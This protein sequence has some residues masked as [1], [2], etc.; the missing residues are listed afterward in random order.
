MNNTV[1]IRLGLAGVVLAVLGLRSASVLSDPVYTAGTPGNIAQV[2]LYIK[3]GVPPLNMLVMGKDTK[4]YFEAYNDASDLDGD[5]A[6]DIG[7]KPGRIDYYGYFN[8]NVCYTQAPGGTLF[9]PTAAATN[10]QCTG[11]WSGDFLNYLTTSRMDALRRVLYGGWRQVDTATQ[12]ILQGAFFPQ[13]GHSWGKEYRSKDANYDPGYDLS[14]YAPYANPAAG[15]YTLFAV[16]TLTGSAN[17]FAAGYQAPLLRVLTN[18]DKRVWNWLSI[19]GP[20][21]GNKCFT[22]NN[23]RVD[24]VGGGGTQPFPGHPGTR[25]AF[26]ALES[27]FATVANRFGSG[28]VADAI[29]CASNDCNPY[30]PDDNYMAIIEGNLVMRNGSNGDGTYQFRIDGDDVVDFTLYGPNGLQIASAGCYTTA[31]RGFGACNGNETSNTVILTRR[32]TYSFKVRQEEAGGGDGY[33]LSWRKTLGARTF[34]WTPID[35]RGNDDDDR[36]GNLNGTTLTTYNLTPS[37]GGAQRDDYLVRVLSC[38]SGNAALRDTTCKGYTSGGTTVYKPTGIL[39]DYGETQKMYFGLITGSQFN[40]LEGGVLRRNISNFADEIDASDGTFRTD[41]NGIA[42]NIDRFRMI[43][44]GYA[45]GTTNNLNSDSNWSWNNNNGNCPTP[46]D[47]QPLNNGECRMWGNPL[48][49]MAYETMRY[50]AGANQPTPRFANAGNGNGNNGRAE[51]ATMGLTTETWKDPYSPRGGNYPSCAKPFQTLISDINPSYDGDLPGSAFAGAN[52]ATGQTP[53]SLDAFNAAAEGQ[54]IWDGEFTGARR[55]FIGEVGGATDGAPTAKTASSFG[56]IRGL[57]PEEPSK[58]GTYYT[59]SVARYGRN[60]DLN[61]ALGQQNM[62]TYSVALASPLPRIDFPV[63][64]GNVTL[65]PFAKTASGTFGAGARKPTNTIVDF[66]VEQI[67]NLPGQPSDGSINGGRPSAIFRINYEDSEQGNDFDMDAIVRYLVQANANGTV[68]VTLN[69]EYA[70]GSADQNMGFVLSGTTQDGVYLEVRDLDAEVGSFRR[71]DLNTPNP[72]LPGQCVGVATG[73]CN[74]QLPTTSTRTFT[75]SS[76]GALATQLRDPLWYAAK[77]GAPNPNQVDANGDGV[78]DNYLLVTNPLNLRTQLSKAFDD[79]ANQNLDV[80]SV[81]ISGARVGSSSFSLQPSYRRGR[82]GADWTG[83]LTAV[84][85]KADG[86]LGATLWN[87]STSLPTPAARR[88]TTVTALTPGSLIVAPTRTAVDFQ[89]TN[90]G[91]TPQAR[92]DALGVNPATIP[93]VYG[94]AYT[95]DDFV[96]YL[97]GVQTNEGAGTLRVRSA[98]LGDIVNSEPVVASPRSDFGYGSYTGAVFSGYSGVGGYVEGKRNRKTVA[99]AG[100]NDGMLHAFD[101]STVPCGGANTNESC[102]AA[103]AGRELF[104]YIPN[105]ALN[106]LG[107][108]ALP[109]RT[110]QHRYSVDGQVTVGD[111]KQNN[112]TWKTVAVGAGGGGLQSVFALDVTDPTA[113]G[114]GQVLWERNSGV[115]NDIGNVYGKPLLVPLQN[116]R[117]AVLF[118]NGYGGRRS[119]PSLYVLDAFTGAV[120]KKLTA[121]DGSVARDALTGLLPCGLTDVLLN[122]AA[123]TNAPFNGL[124]QITAIDRNGDG[125]VDTVYGGD[126]Q[127][128]MWKFDLSN[129]APGNWVVANAGTPL[130]TAVT[131]TERQPITG[132]IRVAAGPG[133]GVLVYFGTGRYLFTGDNDVAPQPQVQSLYAIFDNGTAVSGGRTALVQQTIQTETPENGFVTRGLSN[134]LVSYF[135]ANPKRGWYLDLKVATTTDGI[136]ERFIATPLI[137][138]GRVFFTTYTPTTNSCEPGGSN[139]Q[140]ALDLLSGSGALANVAVLPSGT[141]ACTGANCGGVGIKGPD[142][143]TSQPPVVGTGLVSINPVTPISG[144]TCGG[145]GQPACPTYEE[146]QVVIYPG[147]FVLPRPCGRQSWRQLK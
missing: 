107:A 53:Q 96:A 88:I 4:N 114:P 144:P 35:T 32:T 12:T 39:H 8:S 85:V 120:I 2:P 51:E 21:A 37:L 100:A 40:N 55:V 24:C 134:N 132:G 50:F 97:R 136:G 44:G 72:L 36:S 77:Y 49:E 9:V 103:G 23:T 59:A 60:T 80:G 91:T 48:A 67:A 14:K 113:V 22:A 131:G 117:W 33:R 68:T 78:P 84:S 141:A 65:I 41:V 46:N 106:R 92:Y 20:V 90:L 138:S 42:G 58:A 126:L 45:N 95:P 109:D 25:A 13:D 6:L 140:Y 116:N 27:T 83:N 110:F 145:P 62:S 108:L 76:S 118:G 112:T 16:T 70:A 30:G 66:Y 57:S 119:D 123:T 143:S 115:D 142:G 101:A 43:G 128:N 38:P 81:A 18:T 26:D 133:T 102:A 74:A 61:A 79:I 31:G 15:K 54:A 75:P 10:K 130:F 82:N 137:Q 122:C 47:S 5:G 64:T 1:M 56:N 34:D 129:A 52:N 147:A 93:A 124:G 146:C 69:S 11:L 98:V 99:Y 3:D 7:Y 125:R 105:A 89:A 28:P 87:A 17:T 94:G 127:G 71:Y 135:G 86:T 73:L 29:D 139:F 104:A 19:E 63:G 121:N 111:A